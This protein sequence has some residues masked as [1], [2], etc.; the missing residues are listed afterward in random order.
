MYAV[1]IAVSL[2]EPLAVLILM[3]CDLSAT[4]PAVLGWLR[5]SVPWEVVPSDRAISSADALAQFGY[6]L[7]VRS[8]FA[9]LHRGSVALRLEQELRSRVTAS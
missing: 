3:G 6:S 7:P 5:L 8:V 1:S 9:K 2:N 4:C